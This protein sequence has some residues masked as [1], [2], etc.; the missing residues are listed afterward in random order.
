[1]MATVM[2]IGRI[3]NNPDRNVETMLSNQVHAIKR[4]MVR[5]QIDELPA[6]KWPDRELLRKQGCPS[7]G[8]GPTDRRSPT[9]RYSPA[10][11]NRSE[12]HRIIP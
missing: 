4:F 2:T 12:R 10:S 7:D 1:M 5:P 9:R 6:G 11:R 3:V 8:W